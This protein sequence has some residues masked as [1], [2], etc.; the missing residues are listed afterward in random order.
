MILKFAKRIFTRHHKERVATKLRDAES[1]AGAAERVPSAKHKTEWEKVLTQSLTEN[2]LAPSEEIILHAFD[3]YCD[4]LNAPFVKRRHAMN[5]HLSN[6][7]ASFAKVQALAPDMVERAAAK[8]K[9]E[10]H[11]F[12]D[13]KDDL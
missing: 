4:E 12:I 11:R 2:A 6:I 7:V 9:L 5:G 1:K 8:H 3:L 13:K 10:L